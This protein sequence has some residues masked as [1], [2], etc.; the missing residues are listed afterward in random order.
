M[1]NISIE[2]IIPEQSWQNR[3]NVLME[4]LKKAPDK[5][6]RDKIIDDNGALWRELRDWLLELSHGKCWFSEA[7]DCY[8]YWDVEHYRPKKSAKDEDG[9]Q[10]E[11]YWWLA[12]DWRNFRICGNVGNRRKG[13][14]FPLRQGCNRAEPNGDIRYEQPLLLD[15]VDEYDPNLLS[16]NVEGVAIPAPDTACDWQRYRVEYSVKQLNLDFPPLMNKRKVIWNECWTRIQ[17]YRQEL[18]LYN[19]D[20]TN[21][22]AKEGY[23]ESAKY[24]RRMI[25][26]DS[27]FSAVARACILSS[28]DSRV[29]ALL[30]TS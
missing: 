29:T 18:D 11:G 15:P 20:N 5:A 9:T 27:E 10:H 2:D 25:R 3:A 14:Y 1:R 28:G 4:E 13:T 21:L 17:K 8:S 22:M 6:A 7:K 30:R 16:F 24:V 23:K 26:S 12:F 19:A